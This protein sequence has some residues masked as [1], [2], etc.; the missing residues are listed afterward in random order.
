MMLSALFPEGNGMSHDAQ[1]APDIVFLRNIGIA[2]LALTVATGTICVVGI[3]K[4][5]EPLV[6]AQ[7]V[8]GNAATADLTLI[9]PRLIGWAGALSNI[10]FCTVEVSNCA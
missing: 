4:Y 8:D 6:L 10:W 7:S 9:K 2:L 3:L 1:S 5:G